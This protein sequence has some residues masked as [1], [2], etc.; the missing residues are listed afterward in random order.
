MPRNTDP[1][2]PLPR[3]SPFRPRI[4]GFAS[5][6]S[7]PP[8]PTAPPPPWVTTAGGGERDFVGA[9]GG[10]RGGG[11]RRRR[12]GEG[13]LE[14][15]IPSSPI[16]LDLR[17]HVLIRPLNPPPPEAEAGSS[18]AAAAAAA[19]PPG[20][21][22]MERRTESNSSWNPPPPPPAASSRRIAGG[23]RAPSRARGR[24]DGRRRRRRRRRGGGR[25]CGCAERVGELGNFF[26]SSGGGCAILKM[27]GGWR[28]SGTEL[29]LSTVGERRR[30]RDLG[31][32]K[33]GWFESSSVPRLIWAGWAPRQPKSQFGICLFI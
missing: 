18:R 10:E 2:A 29:P 27:V 7:P 19:L 1:N 4:G 6:S 3:S 24:W 23:S 15:T 21:K 9:G 17:R 25:G 11:R 12:G 33:W 22:E 8:T 16:P 5:S 20:R 26:W 31:G 28:W 30:A 14:A 32:G 13:L